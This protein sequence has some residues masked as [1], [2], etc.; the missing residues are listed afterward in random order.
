MFERPKVFW[1]KTGKRY[2]SYLEKYFDNAG[3]DT[4]H[5]T[6]LIEVSLLLESFAMLNPE[7]ELG[8]EATLLL[9]IENIEALDE[10]I[11]ASSLTSMKNH[12][13]VMVITDLLTWANGKQNFISDDS[14]E[15]FESRIP[16]SSS[17]ES[18]HLENKLWEYALVAKGLSFTFLGMGIVYGE[19]GFDLEKGLVD[20]WSSRIDATSPDWQLP[21]L[22]KI[23]NSDVNTPMI[24]IADFAQTLTEYLRDGNHVSPIFVPAM[25]AISVVSDGE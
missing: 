18:Y 9:D 21:T 6:D 20:F 5:M 15:C 10:V 25:S 24:H 12:P 1:L 3:Y 7:V 16:A 13:K 4:V 19:S 11:R 2:E 23:V 8:L 22:F 17:F 14:V